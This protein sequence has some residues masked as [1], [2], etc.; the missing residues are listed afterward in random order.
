LSRAE[1]QLTQRELNRALLARQGLLERSSAT[2][3][4][5]LERMGGLQAQ[6]APSMY[7]GLW[8]RVDRLARAVRDARRR[9][10]LRTRP[11]PI[12]ERSIA[13]AARA[14]EERL[15]E[16]GELRRKEIEELV[17]KPLAHGVGLW[18]DLVRVPPHG[19]WEKRRADLYGR[20]DKMT[21]RELDAEGERLAEL[22]A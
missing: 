8:S 20:L 6:Y 18:V 4:R 2:L 15:H 1:R 13:K 3:P 19:T 12:P 16:A 5:M 10:W 14:V 7:I 22:H 9:H 11:E 21:R 17:G